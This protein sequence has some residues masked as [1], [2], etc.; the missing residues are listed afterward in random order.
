[1]GSVPYAG[2]DGTHVRVS[3][4][5]ALQPRPHVR[6]SMLLWVGP[7]V[8]QTQAHDQGSPGSSL[9]P[10]TGTPVLCTTLQPHTHALSPIF[11]EPCLRLCRHR[12]LPTGAPSGG[13]GGGHPYGLPNCVGSRRSTAGFRHASTPPSSNYIS[14]NPRPVAKARE[15]FM[16]RSKAARSHIV[17]GRVDRA[18]RQAL[19]HPGCAPIQRSR[20]R[21]RPCVVVRL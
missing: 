18:A 2:K 16:P 17:T 8:E 7:N 11:L 12:G 15:I 19:S 21:S 14:H 6:T 20:P 5:L 4:G 3:N 1:M 10:R 13:Q 9:F